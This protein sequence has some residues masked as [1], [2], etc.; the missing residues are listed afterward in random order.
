MPSWTTA[1][2]V[3]LCLPL[4][5][6]APAAAPGKATLTK[7]ASLGGEW[8]VLDPAG[9]P[10]DLRARYELVAAD[11]AVME[12]LFL[13][14]PEETV[15]LYHLEGA[16]VTVTQL[17]AR[18]RPGRLRESFT[19]D[20][21][22]LIFEASEAGPEAGSLRTLC[23]TFLDGEHLRLEW[24]LRQASGEPL[25]RSHE[26]VRQ[27]SV[28][29]LAR[30][31]SR[32]RVDLDSLQRQVDGRLKRSLATEVDGKPGVALREIRTRPG[33][34]GWDHSG[35]PFRKLLH[36]E[37]TPYASTFSSEGDGG[38]SEAHYAF[39]AGPA[40][41]VSFSV[42]GGHAYVALV[43]ESKAPPR[44]IKD[45]PAFSESLLEGK[46][47]TVLQRVAGERW[48]EHG[49]AIEW[50]LARFAG[51]RL[52]LYVVDAE[53]DRWGQIAISD[54]RITEEVVR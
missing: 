47:G 33:S 29:E 36:R 37:T 46:Y 39:V 10:T 49:A 42:L 4:S 38:L 24:S 44:K 5:I 53:T 27:D 25:I 18:G 22:A 51:V 8:A 12:T 20:D 15:T 41:R 21:G 14:T 7:V 11:S 26:L 34:P 54:V 6:A 32:L 40:C 43:L 9:Q 48:T 1:L 17:S 52:R 19:R 16:H 45:I 31:L 3:G 28:E 50:D 30:K 2:A 13:G 35:V 23:L